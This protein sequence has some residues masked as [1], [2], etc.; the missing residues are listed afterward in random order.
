M[1]EVFTQLGCA[2]ADH[3]P[4][5]GIDRRRLEFSQAFQRVEIV[6]QR[7]ARVVED[8]RAFAQYEVAREELAGRF[9]PEAQAVARMSWRLERDEAVEGHV[10]VLEGTLHTGQVAMAAQ[11]HAK[12]IA[13]CPGQRQVIQVAV[14]D[15][16][17]AGG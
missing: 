6:G 17:R 8:A 15:E 4:V 10:A 13:Q 2:V 12:S 11:R 3:R 9:V 14:R 16:Y 7:P 1:R 5:P